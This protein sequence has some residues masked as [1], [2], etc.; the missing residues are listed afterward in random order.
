TRLRCAP[1]TDVAPP[2][3]EL[4]G[5]EPPV[6]IE[7][8]AASPIEGTSFAYLL[9]DGAAAG[10]H[11][12]QYFEM[13]GS[14][15]IHHDGWKAVTFKPL[16]HMYGDGIDPDAPFDTDRWELY[17]VAEDFSECDDVADAQP[18]QLA[19]LVD[20]WWREARRYSVLPLDNRP[21]A[22][23]MNPRP[24]RAAARSVYRYRPGAPVPETVAVD[25]RNRTH[26]ITATIDVADGVVPSGVLVGLGSTLGGF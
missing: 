9:D 22:A 16:G 6:A 14:R 21:L 19:R 17:H 24:R 8:L 18:E 2:I 10:R 12:T 25:V 13:L 15:A 5:V 11:T 20:L 1:A 4:T 7:G 23:L 3:L 26:R